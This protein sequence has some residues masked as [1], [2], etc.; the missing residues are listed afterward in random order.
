MFKLLDYL[1]CQVVKRCHLVLLQDRVVDS[2]VS[3]ISRD[4]LVSLVESFRQLK[5]KPHDLQV[6][7]CKYVLAKY[8]SLATIYF[9]SS[10]IMAFIT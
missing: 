6:V 9:S 1:R 5:S 8:G 3:V 10:R 4:V 7:C 2:V